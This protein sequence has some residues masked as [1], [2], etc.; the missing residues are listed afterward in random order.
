M[1]AAYDSPPADFAKLW[2]TLAA[3]LG[4]AV[5][6]CPSPLVGPAPARARRR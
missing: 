2:R 5:C 6:W 3:E 1:V 4:V